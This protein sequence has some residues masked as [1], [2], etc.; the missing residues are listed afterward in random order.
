MIKLH[1]DIETYS[2]VSIKDCGVY[3]YAEHPDFLIL[4]VAY[5]FEGFNSSTRIVDLASGEPLPYEVLS[6]LNDPAITKV[7]HNAT[8]ERVCFSNYLR[9]LGKLEWNEWLD[10]MQWRCTMVQAMRCGLPASLE[11]AGAALGLDK[12]KMKEG[13]D[14]IKL[15]CTP[16]KAVAGVFG[17]TDGRVRPEDRPDEWETFKSYCIRDVDVEKQIDEATAWYPVSDF[18]QRLYALDQTINDRGVAVDLQLVN[19]A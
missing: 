6:A 5:F 13:K 8:F 3:K 16:H 12:Q 11:E 19:N 1:I 14:L 9:S 17:E 4:L 7:A 15:F 10:P 2:P 18:E